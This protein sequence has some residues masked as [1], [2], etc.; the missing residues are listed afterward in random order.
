MKLL[1]LILSVCF[2]PSLVM[3]QDAYEI[4]KPI[5]ARSLSGVV[6][7]NVGH[8]IPGVLIERLGPDRK[9]VTDKTVA[10]T[11]GTFG[12]SGRV[13]GK[14]LLR[15]TKDGWSPLYVSVIVDRKT[16]ADLQL[17]MIIAK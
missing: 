12:F 14:H 1:P 10:D 17:A 2:V 15:L 13:K 8:K 6:V 11:N 4:E 3:A 9:T 5:R 16:R 7:D